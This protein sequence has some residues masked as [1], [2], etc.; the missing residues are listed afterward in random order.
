MSDFVTTRAAGLAVM[1]PFIPAMGDQYADCRNY[2]YGPKKHLSVSVLSPYL[3]RRLV[4][5]VEA[6][7]VA[8]DA[9]G[10]VDAAKFVQEVIWRGYFK[11]WLEQRPQVWDNYVNGLN[12]DLVSL[13][14]DCCLP[15]DIALAESGETKLDYF[16]A[17]VNKLIETGYLHNHA[18]MW[19]A[20]IWIFTLAFPWHLGTGFFYRHLLDGDA[21]SNTL[22]WR[23]AAGLH[24]RGKPYPARTENIATFTAGRFRPRNLDLAVVTHGLEATGP[25]GLPPLLQLRN[26]D[27]LKSEL[28]TALLL[29]DEDCRIE[30]FNFSGINICA[31]ATLWCTQLRSP[32]IVSETV[33]LF[34]NGALNDTAI[35]L[36]VIPTCLT[37][38]HPQDLLNWAAKAGA[39]QIFT[40][41]IT[42]G[43]L[44][45]WMDRASPLLA[46]HGITFC[47]QRHDWDEAIWPYA[48][49]GFFRVKKQIPRILEWTVIK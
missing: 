14:R 4:T 41:F 29:T 28:S 6:V 24:A 5:E 39:K 22:N 27:S 16:N 43:P 12:I 33:L 2:N 15:R 13:K 18:R 20:S 40:P 34:E 48:T 32:R 44:R 46:Q 11:G 9:H 31:K 7:T 49:A 26:I 21:E 23:W 47:E 19:F 38:N 8:L 42:R 17:W 35:R 3:R 10:P 36:N 45:D 30:D 1:N 25:G 37:T